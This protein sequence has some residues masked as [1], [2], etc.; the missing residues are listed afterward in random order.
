MAL[1]PCPECGNMVSDTATSC[2]K[3][4]Y[5]LNIIKVQ[6]TNTQKQFYPPQQPQNK[7]MGCMKIGLIVGGALFGLLTLFGIISECSREST[8]T[9]TETNKLVDEPIVEEQTSKID[10][11]AVDKLKIFFKEK[12]DKYASSPTTWVEPKDMPV[13]RNRN[14]IYCYFAK[15]TDEYVGNFRFVFQYAADDWLFIENLVFLI[16]GEHTYNYNPGRMETDNDTG[17]WEWFDNNITYA[18][19]PLI[20]AIANAKTVELKL[21]G[22][23]YYKEKKLTAKQIESIKRTYEYY[24]A[25]NGKF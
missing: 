4:G 5:N 23:K 19:E 15:Y 24:K 17:I 11:V 6:P 10:S 14:G 2:P 18:D 12:T 9:V 1:N 8:E 16:D 21:N 20:K 13:Y 25:L 3:C 22:R 7:P